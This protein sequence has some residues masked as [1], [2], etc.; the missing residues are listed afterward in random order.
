[1]TA[2]DSTVPMIRSPLSAT[3]T[4][5]Q[6]YVYQIIATDSP[7]SYDATNLPLGLSRDPVL[8]FISGT[9]TEAGTSQVTLSATNA[10]GTGTATLTLTVKAAPVS[11]PS[12]ISGTSITGRTG[13]AFTYQVVTSGGSAAARVSATGLPLGLQI[14][15]V[16]GEISGTATSDGS[17][18]VTLTVT[19]AGMSTTSTLQ[20]TFT[21]DPAIP[22]ITSPG[23]ATLIPGQ[24]FTYTIVAPSSSDEATTFDLIGPLPPGLTLD[25]VTGVISGFP[26]Q[27]FGLLPTPNLSGGGP[28][29]NTTTVAC[30]SSGVR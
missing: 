28:T 19:E 27:N 22:V 14:D 23:S 10:N 18:S 9:P 25:H 12:I 17:F 16:T 7:T 5:D 30:N 21:S 3:A 20:L 11:R 2:S 1:M 6:F 4:V 13:S 8:G 15:S 24:P 26:Q 29:D